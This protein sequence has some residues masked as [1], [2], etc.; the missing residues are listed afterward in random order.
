M[1][2]NYFLLLLI[3]LFSV[4]IVNVD[5][6]ENYYV[7]KNGV[8]MTIKQYNLLKESFDVHQI[9]Y[10]TQDF[11]DKVKDLEWKMTT[12]D[13]YI[14]QTNLYSYGSIKSNEE[15]ITAEEF[16]TAVASNSYFHETTYKKIQ[17][18]LGITNGADYNVI[19]LYEMWKMMPKVR[20]YDVI[21]IRG[22]NMNFHSNVGQL[23]ID[24][25]KDGKTYTNTLTAGEQFYKNAGNGISFTIKLPT[26][27]M[28]TSLWMNMYGIASVDI[29]KNATAYGSY[30]H[31]QSAVTLAQA[32][33][34]TFSSTG[35]GGV[36][37]F[38]DSSIAVKFDQMQGVSY[39]VSIR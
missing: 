11:F 38:S 2:K 1:K 5:A 12:Q 24:Y 27:T 37:K 10:F 26:D 21:A 35:L 25:F 14:K 6:K 16:N 3:L 17:M 28:I 9:D 36:I 4:G 13:F 32:K 19:Q 18:N 22:D 15:L 30:Q 33:N 39:P 31:S 8:K 7:N 23:V 34:H 29:T 20:S